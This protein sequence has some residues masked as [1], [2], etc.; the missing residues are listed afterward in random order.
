MPRLLILT[1]HRVLDA[2]DALQPGELC[3]D[4]FRAQM[5]WIARA[6]NPMTL[7]DGVQGLRS[8]RLP[9]RAVTVT[10]DD[11][12]RDNLT[13]ALPI[14]RECGV[15]ATLFVTTGYLRG[16]LPFHE[17]LLEAVRHA[18]GS[19]LDLRELALGAHPV[20]DGAQ[21]LRAWHAIRS[22]VLARAP[23]E[24]VA[25][26]EQVARAAAAPP[27]ARLMLAEDEL[28]TAAA[29]F[30]IGGHT[31]THPTLSRLD[32]PAA[33]RE[34]G[35]GR[36]QLQALLGV[37]PR[38]F[39]YPFGRPQSDFTDRDMAIVERAGFA[40]AVSTSRGVATPAS[41]PFALPRFA[42]WAQRGWR[43]GLRVLREQM[44]QEAAW[45]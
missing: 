44:Q 15:P 26:A 35:D 4:S 28:R 32:A 1:Y 41:R 7:H 20:G 16:L 34:I 38:Y 14:L 12:Y 40:A 25:L 27:L 11:G 17:L 18:R 24:R 31:V 36:Q 19:Q 29:G 2:P 39:A 3:A 30:E 45:P 9:S 43:F 22:A 10:F 5:R 8:G 33:E 21:K 42:P 6:F 13:L 23:T 37:A